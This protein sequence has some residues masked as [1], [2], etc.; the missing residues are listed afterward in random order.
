MVGEDES[1]CTGQNLGGQFIVDFLG[2]LTINGPA[3][4]VVDVEIQFSWLIGCG[5][6]NYLLWR[7]V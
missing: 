2:W 5:R 7:P 3:A 6:N 4:G 1:A